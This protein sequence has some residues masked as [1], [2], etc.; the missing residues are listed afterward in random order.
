VG[1]RQ[2][3]ALS[4]IFLNLTL[5]KVVRDSGTETKVSKSIYEYNK[6]IQTVAYTD[7]IVL[8]GRTTGVLKEAIR[9]LSNAATE[10]GL[11]NQSADN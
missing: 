5:E 3:N 11:N 6:T 9:N 7:D 4:S 1:L 2:G 8:V 10:M